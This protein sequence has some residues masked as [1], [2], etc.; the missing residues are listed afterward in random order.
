MYDIII[1]GGGPAGVAAGVYAARK[2]L[3]TLL[4]T[5]EFGGQSLVSD[6]IENWI[7]DI[8][9]DGLALAKKFESHLRRYEEVLDI[10]TGSRV[11]RVERSGSGFTVRTEHGESYEGWAV[12]VATGGRRRKLAVPGEDKFEGKGVSYCSTCD[13]ALFKGK[14]VAVVGGGNAGLEAAVDLLP[15]AEHVYVVNRSAVLRGDPLTQEEIQKH[16]RV[17]VLLNAQTKSID[18]DAFVSGLTYEQGGEPKTIPVQGVFVEIGSVPNS[19][20]VEGLTELNEKREI[21]VD[22]KR[23]ATSVPGIF[24]A[25]DVTD[26][27]Y[28]QNNIS[29]GDGV[30]AALSAY[31]YVRKAQKTSVV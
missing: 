2:R 1:V 30:K 17:T 29:A 19:E 18:G 3:K 15:Y 27:P 20:P 24:A 25:G 4:L 23:G 9:L 5:E 13:A 10:K 8:H 6:D 12:I 7:G 16:E 14:D 28:K 11:S 22:S 31:D 26:D 21:I